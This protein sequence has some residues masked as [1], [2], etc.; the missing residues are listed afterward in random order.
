M[1]TETARNGGMNVVVEDICATTIHLEILWAISSHLLA[2]ESK[3]PISSLA[4]D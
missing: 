3:L 2:V 1:A 4:L